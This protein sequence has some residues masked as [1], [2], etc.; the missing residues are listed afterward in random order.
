MT[1]YNISFTPSLL[2]SSTTVLPLQMPTFV[3]I[4]DILKLKDNQQ[5]HQAIYN[6]ND[7]EN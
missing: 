5:F 7:L 1:T 4:V 2:A 3:Y 6:S